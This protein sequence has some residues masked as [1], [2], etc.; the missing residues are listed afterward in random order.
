[1]K[2]NPL[3]TLK[4]ILFF[5]ANETW[6]AEGVC[7]TETIGF[8]QNSETEDQKMILTYDNWFMVF[9]PSNKQQRTI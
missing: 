3:I 1:M 7:Y 9:Q 5:L 8:L 6:K 2:L 4:Q